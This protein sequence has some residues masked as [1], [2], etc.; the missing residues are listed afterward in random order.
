MSM[1]RICVNLV[2]FRIRAF[3][4][5]PLPLSSSP[6]RACVES[7]ESMGLEELVDW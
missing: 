4:C 5:D 2:L 6:Q 1:C 3:T 7:C